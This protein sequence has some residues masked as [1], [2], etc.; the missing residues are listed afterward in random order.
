MQNTTAKL[1]MALLMGACLALVGCEDDGGGGSSPTTAIFT[2]SLSGNC[3]GYLSY[4]DTYIDGT[5]AGRITPGGSTSRE[6]SIGTHNWSARCNT[7]RLN[8]NIQQIY[9]GSGGHTQ[10]LSCHNL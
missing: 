1:M 9:V 2:I 8:W 7:G 3:A 10:T 5:F 6:V 4:V